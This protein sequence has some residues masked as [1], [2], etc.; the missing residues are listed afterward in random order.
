M[1]E[2]YDYLFVL[3]MVGNASTG[4]SFLLSKFI[5]GSVRQNHPSTMAVE[6]GSKV[7]NVEGASV[8]L[9]IWDTA[10]RE[11]FR[12]VSR[13]YHHRAAGCLL[14]Y[15]ISDL[16]SFTALKR[17]IAD[18]EQVRPST[19]IFVLVG[20]KKDRE[21]KREVTFEEGM[22]FAAE[23][24]FAG[25]LETSA[26]TG[27]NVEEVFF[28][29]ARNILMKI[30]SGEIDLDQDDCGVYYRGTR[31][32]HVIKAESITRQLQKVNDEREC[33]QQQLNKQVE[34]LHSLL[35]HAFEDLLKSTF[36]T[37]PQNVWITDIH[38]QLTDYLN[39]HLLEHIVQKHGNDEIKSKIEEYCC[40]IANF[41]RNTTIAEFITH[42]Q[43]K[44]RVLR[45]LSFREYYIKLTVSV[46]DREID[47]T[48]LEDV[49]RARCYL[50]QSLS[51]S[52]HTI[53]FFTAEPGTIEMKFWLKSAN[54]K[55][56]GLKNVQGNSLDGNVLKIEMDELNSGKLDITAQ[57]E[58]SPSNMYRTLHNISR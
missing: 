6:W 27:E 33:L 57:V 39:Y 22:R 55:V 46:I 25:F 36:H 23:N 45:M 51:I 20:N 7:V 34:H 4:K 47:T 19:M 49:E 56:R 53:I 54:Y 30:D 12:A 5:G 40:H 18:A 17:W 32:I 48:M 31:P 58:V 2:Q 13:I 38:S 37:I 24:R 16:A 41:Q 28:L 43:N 11:R 21:S 8:K 26:L 15:D 52:L 35:A 42:A 50:S 9:R 3:N 29:C 10:G 44:R 1:P 14:V